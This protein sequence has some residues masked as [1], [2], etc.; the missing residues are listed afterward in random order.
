MDFRN[1]QNQIHYKCDLNKA[2][3]VKTTLSNTEM[4]AKMCHSQSE[5]YSR[6]NRETSYYF[7]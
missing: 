7:S 2:P 6:I 3:Y 4:R 1:P 5:C